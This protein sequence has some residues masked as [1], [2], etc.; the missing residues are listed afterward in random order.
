MAKQ[1]N[2]FIENRP[3]RL[4]KITSILSEHGLNIHAF[5]IQDRGDFGLIKLIVDKPQ[6]AYLILANHGFAC[7]LKDII[8]ISID[9]RPGNLH[10]L[11]SLL[12]E[13][14]IN[15]VDAYGFVLEPAK[16]GICCMEVEN[17]KNN[18]NLQEIIAQGGFTLM[19]DETLYEC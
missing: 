14:N 17:I 4:T 10:K 3:G 15:V 8:A 6:Q 16:N 5:T 13:H 18:D 11:T 19:Q 1:L 12:L 7:A 9:D 2:I